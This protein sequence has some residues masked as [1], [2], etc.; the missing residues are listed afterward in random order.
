MVIAYTDQN[1]CDFA[2]RFDDESKADKVKEAIEVGINAWYEAANDD[3]EP[4]EYWDKEYIEGFYDCGYAEPTM[5]LLDMWGIKHEVVDVEYDDN[6][7][8]ICDELVRR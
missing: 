3:I 4:N 7:N 2:I 6:G 8:V 1:E 5:E